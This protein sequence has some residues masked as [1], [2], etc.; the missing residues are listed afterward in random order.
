M[1]HDCPTCGRTM[2]PYEI[3]LH[4]GLSRL[5]LKLAQVFQVGE[6][7]NS[8]DLR[9]REI[10][11][12]NDYTNMSHLSYLGLVEKHFNQGEREDRMWKLTPLSEEYVFGMPIPKS[13]SVFN[14][15]VV[16]KSPVTV[17]LQTVIGS[18]EP[19]RAWSMKRRAAKDIVGDLFR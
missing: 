2:E 19:P 12:L 10:I 5:V 13:V 17:T 8:K 3:T 16:T 4:A 15:H 6:L 11:S 18:Y 1:S 14:G 9:D 7:F